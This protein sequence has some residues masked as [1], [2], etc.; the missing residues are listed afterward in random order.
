MMSIILQVQ[1]I[2]I[3]LK[4]EQNYTDFTVKLIY[5]NFDLSRSPRDFCFLF[6]AVFLFSPRRSGILFS[7]LLA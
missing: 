2:S 7:R 4:V 5:F 1:F 6:R 3:I